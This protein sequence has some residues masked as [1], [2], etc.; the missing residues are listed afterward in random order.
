M[1]AMETP[2]AA[3]RVW[4][5]RRLAG[6]APLIARRFSSHLLLMLA[7]TAGFCAEIA[8]VASIPT[9]A[10]AVGRRTLF[11]EVEETVVTNRGDLVHIRAPFAL[12]YRYP[13][14]QRGPIGWEQYGQVDAYMRDQLVPKL[15]LPARLQVRHVATRPMPLVQANGSGEPLMWVS[16]GFASDFEQQ[17]EVVEGRLPR[18]T[19]D[20][21]VEA[22]ISA[23]LAAQVGFQVG[24]EYLALGPHADPQGMSVP[25]RIAGIWRARDPHAPYWFYRLSQ[26]DAV[27]FVPEASYRTRVATRDPRSISL[28]LWYSILDA[29]DMRSADVPALQ[30]AIRH[31]VVEAAALLPGTR[32]DLSPERALRDYQEQV[33]RLAILLMVFSLPLLLLIGHFILLVGDLVIQRQSN[34]LAIMRSRGISRL[35]VVGIYLL[36]G[37]LLG[38]LALALGM[39][40]AWM[41]AI[42]MTWTRSFLELSPGATY[43]AGLTPAAWQ[44]AAL[45]LALILLALLVPAYRTA[46]FTI[47][48]SKTE[49]GRLGRPVWWRRVHLDLLLLAPLVYGYLQL[50]RRGTVGLIEHAAP[51]DDP[52][53]NPLL[54]LTPACYIF[55]LALVTMRLYPVV[56]A[57]L[58]WLAGRLPGATVCTALRYMARM[59]RAYNGPVL[60]LILTLS[61]ASFAASMARTLDGHLLDR[62]AYET[63]GDMRLADN[64]TLDPASA[65]AVE[66]DGAVAS[67]SEANAELA[68]FLPVSDYLSIPGV[69]AATRIVNSDVEVAVG[70]RPERARFVGVDRLDLPAVVRWRDDYAREPFGAL[71]NRLAVNPAGVLLQRDFAA[72]IGVSPGATLRLMLDDLGNRVEAPV[73]VVGFIDLFPTVYPEDGPFMIGNLDYVFERQ[74]DQFPYEVWLRLAPGTPRDDVLIGAALRGFN[75]VNRGYAPAAIMGERTR[76]ERQGVFGLLSAGFVATAA[77]TVLGLL[78]HTVVSFR[79]RSV[80]LGLLRVIGLSVRQLA[81]L[82]AVEQLVILASGVIAGTL[83]GVSASRLFVP[84]LQVDG[85][86]HPLT[87]PFAVRIN[88]GSIGV[89]YLLFGALLLLAMLVTLKLV[90]RLRLFQIIKL[91]ETT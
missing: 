1:E 87:P 67:G 76:P 15:G 88:W 29:R 73:V 79:R 3:R 70:G 82:L 63:G 50:R 6:L 84:L 90:R 31:S 24:E 20:G 12:V 60:L 52:F 4:L 68:Q 53:N 7:V 47:V 40:L 34:E 21:P 66:F 44:S 2:A 36:E 85:G 30:D 42:A 78:L 13:G 57:T 59:P 80:E 9:Y 55:A 5:P 10:E 45:A 23:G 43:L 81:A 75:V 26:L 83:I 19:A 56:I 61:L 8:L 48:S 18:V 28:A 77:L 62:V 72:R 49:R 71:L 37:L 74:G 86:E 58:A 64:G 17:I 69:V 65:A 27:W 11:E 38:V 39:P 25:V 32:L 41:T 91:G 54:L 33:Q 14:S 51:G 22:M 35:Q 16:L 46:Y 89:I